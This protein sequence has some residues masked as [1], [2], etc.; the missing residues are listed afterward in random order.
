MK[1]LSVLLSVAS[2]SGIVW[3]C[4]VGAE[5]IVGAKGRSPSRQ[6]KAADLVAQSNLTR[7]TR[8]EVVQT[9]SGLELVLKTIAGSERL[10]PL[11]LPEG[12][13]LVID[14]LDGDFSI[15]D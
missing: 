4:P 13:D 5:G 11:I 2:V 7:V 12:N 9:E 15:L 14:I 3:V 6:G 1:L 8:V 10:V